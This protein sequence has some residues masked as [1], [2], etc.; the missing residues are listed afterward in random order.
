MRIQF[1]ISGIYKIKNNIKKYTDKHAK[2]KKKLKLQN[3]NIEN[4]Q[5]KCLIMSSCS[6]KLLIFIRINQWKWRR[7]TLP[8]VSIHRGYHPWEHVAMKYHQTHQTQSTGRFFF[9]QVTCL[10]ALQFLFKVNNKGAR[11]RYAIHWNMKF[12]HY[13]WLWRG[14][15]ELW[16]IVCR[17]RVF[18]L[19]APQIHSLKLENFF[20]SYVSFNTA[21]DLLVAFSFWSTLQKY[22]KKWFIIYLV[23]F[24][25]T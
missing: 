4:S 1:L 25:C 8:V 18:F 15:F 24:T 10:Q 13:Y 23:F 19:W 11:T 6:K 3:S 17:G 2:Q 7:K 16:L 14:V 22:H 12:T 9:L 21:R 20:F 5:L